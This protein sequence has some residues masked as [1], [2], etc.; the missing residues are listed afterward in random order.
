MARI[1]L[2]DD[3]TSVRVGIGR[4]LR[5]GGHV[6]HD[7]CDGVEALRMAQGLELDLVITDINMPKMDGI[8][9]I[10]ALAERNPGL[11]VIAISGGGRMPKELLLA[12]AGV[13]GAVTTLPKPFELA[14]L[15][16]AVDGALAAAEDRS[17]DGRH[18]ER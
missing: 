10:L 3:E 15:W 16:D 5:K 9:V 12:S 14:Q 13:L 17:G 4:L 2:I 7:A 6:V 18:H 8:E 1:L 11:P